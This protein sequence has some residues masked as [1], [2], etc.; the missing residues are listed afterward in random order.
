M[1]SDEDIGSPSSQTPD[2]MI[3]VT[4]SGDSADYQSPLF[5]GTGMERIMN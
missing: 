3:L 2:E 4:S 5:G 1:I